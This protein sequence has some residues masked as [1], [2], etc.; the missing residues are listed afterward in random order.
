MEPYELA[1]NG[2]PQL[3]VDLYNW[4]IELAAAMFEDLGTVE[5]LLRNALDRVLVTRYQPNLGSQDWYLVDGVLL[6]QQGDAVD[7][8]IEGLKGR[9][10]QASH[11]NVISELNFTFWRDLLGPAY[12][13][14]LWNPTLHL[15]FRHAQ[16][17]LKRW[18]VYDRVDHL[19]D[20]RNEIAHH[21]PIFE[22]DHQADLTDVTMLAAAISP[23][24]QGWLVKRSRVKDV[25][26]Q[27]PRQG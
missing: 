16:G 22:R 9:I 10:G 26:G 12:Q 3:V 25:L 8:A 18:Q 2:D 4:N 6:Q 20:L 7:R 14:R 27:D 1:A 24:V 17:A 21:D 13:E 15:A 19:C 23:V 11:D 5:V